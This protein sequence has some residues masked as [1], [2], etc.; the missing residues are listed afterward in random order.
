[1]HYLAPDPWVLW[2]NTFFTIDICFYYYFSSDELLS[3]FSYV[4]VEHGV[5]TLC[6]GGLLAYTQLKI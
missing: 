3:F 4:R 6:A 1:V 5:G 2:G